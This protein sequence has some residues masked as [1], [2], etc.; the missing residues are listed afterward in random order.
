MP[1]EYL[2]FSRMEIKLPPIIHYLLTFLFFA[3]SLLPAKSHALPVFSP[4]HNLWTIRTMEL[5]PLDSTLSRLQL[6]FPEQAVSLCLGLLEDSKREK[7]AVLQIWTLY[8]AVSAYYYIGQI[9]DSIKD[10][11]LLNVNREEKQGISPM[12]SLSYLT[13]GKIYLTEEKYDLSFKYCLLAKDLA[14]KMDDSTQFILADVAASAALG[15][16]G[17]TEE[18][19][20]SYQQADA[21][22]QRHPN[23]YKHLLV[24]FNLCTAKAATKAPADSLIASL[25]QIEAEVLQMGDTALLCWSNMMKGTVYLMESMIKS[26]VDSAQAYFLQALQYENLFNNILIKTV[27]KHNIAITYISQNQPSLALAYLQDVIRIWS[28]RKNYLHLMGAYRSLSECMFMMGRYQEAYHYLLE[29]N[30]IK[31]QSFGTDIVSDIQKTNMRHIITEKDQQLDLLL[32][33]EELTHSRFYVYLF[34]SISVF[35]LF[36]FIVSILTYKNKA[37][38]KEKENNQKLYRLEIDSKNREL[39]S[40]FLLLSNKNSILSK[41]KNLADNKDETEAQAVLNQ[42]A[43][44]AE[45]NLKTDDEWQHFQLHFNKVHPKFFSRLHNTYPMLTEN[46]LRLCAYIKIGLKNKEIATLNHISV[47]SVKMNRW[48]LKRKMKIGTDENLDGILFS[49]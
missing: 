31:Q 28:E 4:E 42:I 46:D 18:A 40:S 23:F 47:E 33:K 21:Y 20:L 37:I 25:E 17:E 26:H 35:L 45:S 34:F 14:K 19:L 27:L 39:A 13:L 3:C 49:L 6:V 15:A 11:V 10:N 2:S 1:D 29:S 36:V 44:L 7:D 32:Q 41:I 5:Q 22:W 38:H 30:N 8:Q 16:L 24:R 43:A 9:P 12:L 48:R